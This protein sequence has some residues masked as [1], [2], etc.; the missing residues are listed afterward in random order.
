MVCLLAESAR[1]LTQPLFGYLHHS[2]HW[3]S[4]KNT[5]LA[6][7]LPVKPTIPSILPFNPNLHQLL[8][9]LQC[10]TRFSGRQHLRH[11][12]GF[13]KIQVSKVWKFTSWIHSQ[14]WNWIT[15]TQEMIQRT[16]A[17]G[18]QKIPHPWLND[19]LEDQ[20]LFSLLP[21]LIS[22][23]SVLSILTRWKANGTE[24]QPLRQLDSCQQ[25]VWHLQVETPGVGQ[26]P[27]AQPWWNISLH[28]K[29][30]LRQHLWLH[31]QFFKPFLGGP[32]R[33]TN[34]TWCPCETKTQKSSVFACQQKI[35]WTQFE[36]S[37]SQIEK[38]NSKFPPTRDECAS[39]R[40]P[41]SSQLFWTLNPSPSIEMY[42]PA[43][44]RRRRKPK[45]NQNI[46]W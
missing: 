40:C 20:Y 43:A 17:G 45:N 30:P 14:S 7:N 41:Y 46:L 10:Q 36:K 34:T 29:R 3:V 4:K 42:T 11:L 22:K 8:K 25:S 1:Y 31:L 13:Q 38:S 15:D 28:L 26:T 21:Q 37:N 23:D 6:R 24:F 44:Y 39:L 27:V 12:S 5:K 32:K 33:R 16:L 2:I 35:W 19:Q 18:T 9:P